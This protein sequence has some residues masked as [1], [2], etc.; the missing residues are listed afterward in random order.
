MTGSLERGARSDLGAWIALS[1]TTCSRP[2]AGTDEKS[3][4]E[5]SDPPMLFGC[6]VPLSEEFGNDAAWAKTAESADSGLCAL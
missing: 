1:V 6:G 3:R 4:A 5:N 2:E